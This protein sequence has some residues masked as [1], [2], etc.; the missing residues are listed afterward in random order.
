LPMYTN[1]ALRN[2]AATGVQLGR[3]IDARG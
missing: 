2:A 1:P 3:M